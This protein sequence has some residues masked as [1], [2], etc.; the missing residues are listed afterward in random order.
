ML[1]DQS[2]SVFFVWG[3]SPYAVTYQCKECEQ[4]GNDNDNRRSCGLAIERCIS[5][6]MVAL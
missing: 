2:L 3:V 4:Y 6:T 1:L 5:C